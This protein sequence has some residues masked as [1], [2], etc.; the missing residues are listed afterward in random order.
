[1]A[2][3]YELINVRHEAG[4]DYV[5]LNRPNIRNAVNDAVIEEL[6]HWADAAATDRRLRLAVLGGAGKTFCAG[7]DLGWMSRTIDY[8]YEANLHDAWALAR[9]FA[10]L[11]TLPVPLVGRVHGAALGGGV[12]LVAVCDIAVATEDTVFGFT[13]VKLG[14]VPAVISPYAVAKIGASAARHL[15]LSGERF[16]AR[17]AYELGLIHV[18]TAPDGLDA[19]VTRTVHELL[20]AGPQAIAAAKTLIASVVDRQ[21]STVTELTVGAI[22]DLR[23][24]PE[25]QEGMRAFLDKRPPSWVADES[26]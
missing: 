7:A 11:D 5:T 14:I 8:E 10:R 16:S 9:L 26:S 12:G 2:A 20:M 18:I 13:E 4:I 17:R 24:T 21:P 15:F 6:T 23:V 19:G 1:M 22:A 25:A 3:S